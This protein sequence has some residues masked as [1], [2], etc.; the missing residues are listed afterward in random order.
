MHIATN[1]CRMAMDIAGYLANRVDQRALQ[2][3]DFPDKPSLIRLDLNEGPFPP[4]KEVAE[5]MR[6]A[7]GITQRY[8]DTAARVLS[9]KIATRLHLPASPL[10]VGCGTNELIA[11]SAM[12]FLDCDSEVVVPRPTF[13]G[14]VKTSLL[15]GAKVVEVDVNHDGSLDIDAMLNKVTTKTK[16]LYVTS[17]HNPTGHILAEVDFIRLVTNLPHHVMLYLDEAYY[18]FGVR[19]GAPNYLEIVKKRSYPWISTRT[20]SKAYGLAGARVGY[21]IASSET[22]AAAYRSARPNFTTNLIGMA[23]AI[24]A[25]DTPQFV[26]ESLS[27]IEKERQRVGAALSRAGC[28]VLPTGANFVMGVLPPDDANRVARRLE[29]NDIIVRVIGMPRGEAGLRVTIGSV[30]DNDKLL[31]VLSEE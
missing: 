4:P 11:I 9:S 28:R 15:Q 24:A 30:E 14:H 12:L 27:V 16:L 17:P 25:M 26:D 1:E 5:A 13:V 23:G 10:V 18:E 29:Q 21:G 8:P 2:H 3:E 19:A 6:E 20:F 31:S 22:V 7:A